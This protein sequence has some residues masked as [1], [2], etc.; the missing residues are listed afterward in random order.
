MCTFLTFKAKM[1]DACR[2][3]LYGVIHFKK[4]IMCETNVCKDDNGRD[5]KIIDLL[6]EKEREEQ[7][8]NYN[9]NNRYVSLSLY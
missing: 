3:L 4:I 2:Y 1:T 6:E 7:K 8:E 9:K 5:D